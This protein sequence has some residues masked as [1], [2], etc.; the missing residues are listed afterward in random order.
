MRGAWT[1]VGIALVVV[2]GAWSLMGWGGGKSLARWVE[3]SQR[4]LELAEARGAEEGVIQGWEA[5]VDEGCQWPEVY[6]NWGNALHRGGRDG[7]AALAYRRALWLDPGLVEARQNL[8]VL[9]LRQGFLAY[10]DEWWQLMV[11]R[12]GWTRW[13]GGAAL[14]GWL[15]LIGLALH[16]RG[17]GRRERLA[18]GW[19]AAT[20]GLALVLAVTGLVVGSKIDDPAARST[21]LEDGVVARAEPTRVGGVVIALPP[22]SEVEV[23]AERGDWS[24]VAIPAGGRDGG[25][26]G[27]VSSVVLGELRSTGY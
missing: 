6:Y 10:Q 16:W 14:A 22:G 17:E 5:L 26:R 19:V 27:W 24:Y 7:E 1:Y 12:V 4:L 20:G 8:A 13:A 3:E 9:G 21:V 11:A 15:V 18:A 25:L 23:L 2:A